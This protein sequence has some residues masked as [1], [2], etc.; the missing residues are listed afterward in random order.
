MIPPTLFTAC[1]TLPPERAD[2]PSGRP[3]EKEILPEEIWQE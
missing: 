1:D 2:F 3:G